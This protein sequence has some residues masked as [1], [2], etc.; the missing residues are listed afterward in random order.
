MTWDFL[1]FWNCSQRRAK[2]KAG[3]ELGRLIDGCAT[4][5]AAWLTLTT[6]APSI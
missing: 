6:P 5:G 4:Q 2:S 1:L 3:L